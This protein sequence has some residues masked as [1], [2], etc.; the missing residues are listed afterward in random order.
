MKYWWYTETE[1][2]QLQQ[3]LEIHT[4]TVELQHDSNLRRYQVSGYGVQYR[5]SF[6]HAHCVC[7]WLLTITCIIM[8]RHC[9]SQ[10]TN[11]THMHPSLLSIL[12][13]VIS[14]SPNV[15]QIL[16]VEACGACERD[17][18]VYR[19]FWL[20]VTFQQGSNGRGELSPVEPSR[21]CSLPIF[22][23]WVNILV[24]MQALRIWRLEYIIM[25]PGCSVALTWA[26]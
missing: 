15:N 9:L 8:H 6:V 12:A 19:S 17:E 14:P 2:V 13:S 4:V 25:T 7:T 24:S 22:K 16:S 21:Q 10:T 11:M 1:L 5:T 18:I 20:L 26:E 23:P 3:C